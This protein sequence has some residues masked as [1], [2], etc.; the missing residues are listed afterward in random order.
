MYL[1]DSSL[2]N[3]YQ[4]A[5]KVYSSSAKNGDIGSFY[6]LGQIYT[7]SDSGMT[8]M[9]RG[10]SFY[11]Y[12][13]SEGFVPAQY[14]LGTMYVNGEGV[15]RNLFLG[16]AWLELAASNRYDPAISALAQLDSDM[17]LSETENAKKEFMRLQQEVLGRVESP[18][19]VEERLMAEEQEKQA[20]DASHG[21]RRRP[22]RR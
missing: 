2:P 22:R 4:E 21:S 19:V 7:N 15:E 5:V 16:H 18:F 11:N 3:R 14:L 10:V 17:T 13:A 12:A 20:S 8:D 1:S 9:R 6:A